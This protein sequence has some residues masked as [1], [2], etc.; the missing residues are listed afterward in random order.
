MSTVAKIEQ[1]TKKYSD[2]YTKL[3]DKVRELNDE[4]DAVKRKHMR[5]IKDFA[6]EA[7]E[8]KSHLSDAIQEGKDLFEKPKS[9][10][11]HGMKVELQKGKGK[12][13]MPDEEKTI[14]L[15]RKNLPD[16]SD[17]L[18]KTKEVVIKP[19]LENLQAND[20]KKI[21]VNLT[22]ST[23]QVLI[24]PTENDVDKIVNALL[25]DDSEEDMTLLDKAAV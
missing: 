21:G 11:F 16:Q 10:I 18:I 14:L 25:K 3:S 1:L 23:D 6:N 22:E 7:L 17:V 2:S 13:T 5:Y 12:I 15:I 9:I 19:A 24:K 4:L 20:L 8:N